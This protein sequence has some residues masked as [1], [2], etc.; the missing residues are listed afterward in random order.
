MARDRK[1]A[2]AGA[3]ESQ[4]N[5]RQH[6][7]RPRYVTWLSIGVVILAGVHLA[8]FK[9]ALALPDLPY[10]APRSYLAI[11]NGVWA[12]G[13]LLIAI[14]VFIGMRW[15]LLGIRWG[16]IGL[17]LWYWGDRLLFARSDFSRLSLPLNAVFTLLALGWIFWGTN[18]PSVR[19]FYE[20][21]AS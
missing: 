3:A 1:G 12:V 13:E 4:M 2:K 5:G 21:S 20:E 10:S 6:I 17:A 11:R 7:Q 16:G 14:G 18:R 19:S 15:S 9:A 8:G